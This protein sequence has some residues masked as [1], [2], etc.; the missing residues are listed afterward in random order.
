MGR[1]IVR[2]P[3]LFLFDELLSNLDAALRTELRAEIRRLQA[4]LGVTTLYVTHDHAE[5]FTVA[6]LVA[7]M[8][9]GRVAQVDK[10]ETLYRHPANEYVA[11]FLGFRNLVEGVVAESNGIDSVIGRLYPQNIQVSPG[12]RVTVLI[13][14]EGARIIDAGQTV[15]PTE[16][17]ISGTVKE[18]LFKGGHVNLTIQTEPAFLLN[19]D[20]TLDTLPPSTGQSIRLALGPS[21]MVLIPGT[22]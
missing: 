9:N 10:P 21:A 15:D 4:A 17:T 3:R 19:F 12:T 18:R 7:V 8:N 1:A 6:D 13:R 16:T 14:P 5:A 11:R 22:E 20:F 2:Q